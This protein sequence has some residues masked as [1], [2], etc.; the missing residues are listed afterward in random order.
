M[1]CT[2]QKRRSVDIVAGS[3]SCFEER[4]R[5]RRLTP[6]IVRGTAYLDG[7][8]SK[9]RRMATAVHAAGSARLF[10]L[11]CTLA[12]AQGGGAPVNVRIGRRFLLPRSVCRARL[13]RR[14]QLPL[15]CRRLFACPPVEVFGTGFIYFVALRGGGAASKVPIDKIKSA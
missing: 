6:Q 12:S 1:R 3:L 5:A 14:L 11:S 9:R 15:I 7:N 13:I 10:V 2:R 8:S 4:K